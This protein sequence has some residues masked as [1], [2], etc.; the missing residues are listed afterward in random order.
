MPKPPPAEKPISLHPLKPEEALEW[1]LKDKDKEKE[2]KE[3]E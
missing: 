2:K 1:M 3:E